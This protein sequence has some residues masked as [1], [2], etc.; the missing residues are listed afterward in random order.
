MWVYSLLRLVAGFGR[1]TIGTCTLV[2]STELV[3]KRWR[4]QVGILGF[5]FTFGF[6]SL[7]WM[8]Y[9]SGGASWRRLY[10]RTSLPALVYCIIVYLLV[11]ESPRWLFVKGHNDR[12]IQTLDK[13]ATFNGKELNHEN[14]SKIRVDQE[15]VLD[16]GSLNMYSAMKILEK[17]KWAFRRL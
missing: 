8:A 3:G 16:G 13:I 15:E 5:F 4:G 12:A 1:A 2:L 11:H 14:F 17:R 9:S 6:L 7:P 10:L